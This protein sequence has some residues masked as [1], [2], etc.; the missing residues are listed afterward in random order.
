[1][2][3]VLVSLLMLTF[4]ATAA[5]QPRG[6]VRDNRDGGQYGWLSSLTEGKAAARKAGKPLLVMLRCVP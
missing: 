6:A 3:S 1:M 4:A 2:Q 5:A